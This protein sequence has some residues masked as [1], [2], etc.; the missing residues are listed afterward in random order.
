M[1]LIFIFLVSSNISIKIKAV[2]L[3]IHIVYFLWWYVYQAFGIFFKKL[4]GSRLVLGVSEFFIHP[5]HN[6]LIRYLIS[7]SC[8]MSFIHETKDQTLFKLTEPIATAP[9]TR[10]I[11]LGKLIPHPA[12]NFSNKA[13]VHFT[14]LLWRPNELISIKHLD[15]HSLINLI[16]W[17]KN[18]NHRRSH[19]TLLFH[20]LYTSYFSN[21]ISDNR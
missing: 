6:S 18:I 19:C 17:S 7:P 13:N 9:C 14:K 8:S 5:R 15:H 3:Y 20:I 12:L 16:K 4:G 11:T 1:I 21:L 10:H 2:Y